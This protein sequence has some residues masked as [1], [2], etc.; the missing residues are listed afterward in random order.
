MMGKGCISVIIPAYNREYM[1]GNAIESV[2]SQSYT[3]LEL[4]VVDD[5]STDDTRNVARS[6]A[7]DR[8]RLI[9]TDHRG[10]YVARNTGI[11]NSRGEYI[12]FLDSDDVWLPGKLAKQMRVAE[13]NDV[14]FVSTNGFML[15]EGEKGYRMEF[16]LSTGNNDYRGK[17]YRELLKQNFISTSSVMMSKSIFDDV[18]PF[19]AENRGRLDYEMWLRVAKKYE[20]DYISQPLFLYKVHADRLSSNTIARLHD[21]L[22]VY[23]LEEERCSQSGW[24]AEAYIAKC[25]IAKTWLSFGLY[26]YG[27]GKGVIARKYFSKALTRRDTD[28]Y[29]RIWALGCIVMPYTIYRR[30]Y[31]R[32]LNLKENLISLQRGKITL[33]GALK[34]ILLNFLHRVRLPKG[35]G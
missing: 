28:S 29:S 13:R 11:E 5:G 15:S 6:F 19:I 7:D 21:R 25:S 31:N 8:I 33:K 23:H 32:Y 1:V 22:Y 34:Y 24:K 4:I 20:I 27:S 9:E 2:L 12:A 26:Y 14:A 17:C 16:M 18:G 3:N 10:A 30:L 35:M